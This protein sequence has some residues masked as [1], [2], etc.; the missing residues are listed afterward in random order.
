LA[1]LPAGRGGSHRAGSVALVAFGPV[2]VTLPP[3]ARLSESGNR[4]APE[5]RNPN[6]GQKLLFPQQFLTEDLG[7][8]LPVRPAE[9]LTDRRLGTFAQGQPAGDRS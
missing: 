7:P 3:C 1:V 8:A 6:F 9:L 4:L 2:S 5:V